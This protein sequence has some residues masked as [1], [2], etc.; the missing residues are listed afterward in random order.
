M[1]RMAFV[2]LLSALPAAAGPIDWISRIQE[3]SSH[4]AS[5][6]DKTGG[7]VDS[8]MSLEP[9]VAQVLLDTDGPGCV[10][11]LWMTVSIFPGHTQLWRDLIVRMYWEKSPVP[12]VEVPLGDFFAMGHCRRYPVQSAPISV[13]QHPSALNCYWPMP[14]HKH[15]RIELYNAGPRS[16]RRFYYQIDYELGPIDAS[17]GLFH[18]VFRRDRSVRGQPAT[19]NVTG[20]DNYVVLDTRGEGQYVG[21]VLFVDSQRG[22]N[23]F[24]GDDMIFID[25]DEKPR[26]YGTGTEDYFCNAWGYREAFSYPYYGAPL[27]EKRTAD[28][29]LYAALYRWHIVDPIHFKKSIRVTFEH[30]FPADVVNDYSSVAFW[31]QRRP[32][33]Q[34]EPLPKDNYPLERQPAPTRSFI[35]EVDTTE[36]EA[37]LRAK[38]IAARAVATE[39]HAGYT[40]GGYLEIRTAGREVEITIPVAEDGRYQV[41]LKPVLHL[42]E[43]QIRA[44]LTGG[45]MKAIP[46]QPRD[47]AKKVQEHAVPFTHLGSV[48]S[49]GKQITLTVSGNDVIGLDEI[50]VTRTGSAE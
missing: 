32:I 26:L 39:L 2:L 14:F 4:R 35:G 22:E 15:A 48:N 21:C 36:F 11:H 3:R 44:G 6:Y 49:Q 42:I 1:N 46:P 30:L 29:G 23:W 33:G 25:D 10:R 27:L 13:G 8:L 28:N 24:E 31:Y 41:E 40:N 45:E 19:G 17:E 20:R 50:R 18:A 43:G 37:P 9:G 16:V 5:S 38:G 12:S 47:P 7:N 34:R